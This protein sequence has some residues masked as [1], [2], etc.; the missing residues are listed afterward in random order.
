MTKTATVSSRSASS[1]RHFAR[2]RAWRRRS[3]WT[4]RT[5]PGRWTTTRARRSRSGSTRTTQ[6][7]TRSL[8]RM[9]FTKSSSSETTD[10]VLRPRGTRT[11]CP[12]RRRRDARRTPRRSPRRSR[13]PFARRP[14]WSGSRIRSRKEKRRW[15]S[16]RRRWSGYRRAAARRRSRHPRHPRIWIPRRLGTGIPRRRAPRRAPRRNSQGSP[17]TW[18]WATSPRLRNFSGC[19]RPWTSAVPPTTTTWPTSNPQSSTAG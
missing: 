10:R 15:R 1:S 12:R 4:S 5:V 19:R 16:S 6:T 13:S 11:M 14:S 3:G 2:I 18:T 7:A 17:A 9:N 8:T